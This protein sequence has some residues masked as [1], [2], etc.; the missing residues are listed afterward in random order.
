MELKETEVPTHDNDSISPSESRATGN[1]ISTPSTAP[2]IQVPLW[3]T[4]TIHRWKAPLLMVIFFII[5]FAMSLAHCIFYPMLTGVIVGNPDS[6]E[7]KIRFGTA[8]AFISQISLSAAVWQSFTQWLWVTVNGKVWGLGTLN[9]A[10]SGSFFALFNYEML[11]KLRIGSAMALFAW[12]LLLPPFFTPATLFVVPSI[13]SQKIEWQMPYPAIADGR[14][15]SMLAYSPPILRGTRQY[16][17]DVSRYFAGP[18]TIMSLIATATASLG[19]I[20]PISSPYNT[21]THAIDFY[22]PIVK[23]TDASSSEQTQIDGFL[24]EE[25]A[26]Q[27]DITSNETDSAYYCFVPTWS[28][29][30]LTAVSK[31][32]QQTLSN[33]TNQLWMTFL[34]Y[35]GNVNNAGQMVKE[36]RYQI[37]RLFNSTYHVTISRDRGFQNV[38]G[39]YDVHEEV[40][41]PNDKPGSISNMAQ[42]AY[43]AFMWQLSDQLIGKLSWFE[44]KNYTTTSSD[45]S[46]PSQFAVINSQISRT[47]LL[48][49]SDLDVFFN[50]DE[51][52]WL[53]KTQ[54]LTLSDQR[55][56]DKALAKNRT[57]DVLIEELSFNTTMSLMHDPLLTKN[58]L[59][60]VLVQTPVNRYAYKHPGLFIPYGLANLFTFIIVL[61]GLYSYRRHGVKPDRK[62]QDLVELAVE[63]AELWQEERHR[64]S[65][66]ITI[67]RVGTVEAGN[68]TEGSGRRKLSIK[69]LNDGKVFENRRASTLPR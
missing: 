52:H 3:P 20:L 50:L 66:T 45:T 62:F 33:G 63:H 59:T 19:E 35:T 69:W 14:Y 17:D 15:G 34:R 65:V 30:Q 18:R 48:G 8:F 54:N 2:K 5:G 27:T 13:G 29:G 46:G 44:S 57:L 39:T 28:S 41:Y 49:S 37:C 60:Q 12:S 6:Q 55:L 9:D 64:G 26:N 21:S 36:R 25:M 24:R 31:P 4:R 53:Y 42:H 7:G 23:C 51:E 1:G 32:R 38:S 68:R 40:P 58:T 22:A 67:S 43:T 16:V 56:Q 10:F 47:S 11:K 61:L